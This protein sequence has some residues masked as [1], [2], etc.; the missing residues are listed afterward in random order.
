MDGIRLEVARRALRDRRRARVWWLFGVGL[1]T[2]AIVAAFPAMEGQKE[3]N[4]ILEEYPPELLALFAGGQTTFDL[5]SAGDYLNSQLFA[6]IAPMLLVILGVGFA[7]GT[8][9]GEE[10]RGTLDLVLTYPVSRVSVVLQKALVL[11]VEV[12]LLTLVVHLVAFGVGRVF[13]IELPLA[14]VVA[15]GLA[16]LLLG[17]VFGFLT[18]AA[19]AASGSRGLSIGV[20]AGTAAGTYLVGSLA[21]VVSWLEPV[22][23]VSP[24]FYATGGNPLVNG[25]PAWRIILL[26]GSA[27]V[28]AVVAVVAFQRRDV[29]G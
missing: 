14:D 11:I 17:V 6:F 5:A 12:A 21:P 24:F 10:E 23:W 27:A 9:A 1:Y 28:L 16:Q 18:L 2:L 8:L 7:A 13:E 4:R 20:G 26:A 15:A 3:I 19:A 29:R 22:K 25:L